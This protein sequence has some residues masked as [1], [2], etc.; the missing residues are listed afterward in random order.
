M[1]IKK[2]KSC[3]YMVSETVKKHHSLHSGKLKRYLPHTEIKHYIK[4]SNTGKE[5]DKGGQTGRLKLDIK[6]SLFLAKCLRK[7]A[8]NNTTVDMG[9]NDY[10]LII[11]LSSHHERICYVGTRFT[12]ICVT[13]RLIMSVWCVCMWVH[14][15]I[16][17]SKNL[18]TRACV[19]VCVCVCVC[20]ML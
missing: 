4:W 6:H 18:V 16:T 1:V 10:D 14:Y 2:R 20:I 9:W 15:A 12:Q 8:I 11:K 7:T 3:F 17:V 5:L 13:E 19:C